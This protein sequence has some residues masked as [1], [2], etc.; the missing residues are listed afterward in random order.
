MGTLSLRVRYRPV[1][2]GW[3]VRDGNLED[4][5][6]VLRLTHTLWGGRY[7]PIIPVGNTELAT[8]LVDVFRVDALYPVVDDTQ[9]R[10][11]I[12]QFPH[13]PWP[14]FHK[15]FFIEGA[16]G[17]IATFL[18][19]YHPVRHLFEEFV[20]DKDEPRISATLYEWEHNDPLRDVFLAYFGSYP[21][22]DETG[23]DYS[24]FVEQ[25]LKGKR[26]KLGTTDAVPPDAYRA[27]TPS[28][29]SAYDLEGDRPPPREHPGLYVGSADD[30][31]D[32]VNFWNLRAADIAL[33]FDD[34]NHQGRLSGFTTSYLD[35]LR[36]RPEDPSGWLDRIAVWSKDRAAVEGKEFGPKILRRTVSEAIWNGL[37]LKPPLMQI[38]EEQSVLASVEDEGSTPSLSFQ[39]PKKPFFDDVGFFNQQVITSLRPLVGLS[40]SAETTF[41]YPYIP[42][43]NEYYG[44]DAHF[45]W[46][47]ARAERDGLGIVTSVTS[48]HLNIRALVKRQLVAKIFE[49]FGMKC[50]PSQPGRIAT[51][52]IHQMGGIQGCR[53]FKIAGVRK[54]IEKYGPLESFTRSGAVQVVGQN[55]PVTG[56]PNFADYEDLFIETRKRGKLKPEH[57]FTYLV[58][59]GVFRVGLNLECPNCDLNFWM[60]LDDIGTE[61]ECEYCGQ[62]FNITTQLRDRDWA[63][64]RSGLFGKEDH[65]QGSIPVLLTLQQLDTTLR[66]DTLFVTNMNIR[67]DTAQINP[68]ETDFVLIS[69][70][71]Y[72]DRVQLAIGECKS[73]GEEIEEKDVA[74]LTRVADAFPSKH[75]ETFIV[76]SKTAPFTP[77]EVAR[78]RAAQLEH[79]LRVVLLSDRELEPYFVYRRAEKEFNIRSTAI[80]LEAMA[81]ATHGIY[82]EPKPKKV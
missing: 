56:R 78:C 27:L 39:L 3:C 38:A 67:P 46:N 75:I 26:V 57:A 20:K 47:V 31:T 66:S 51:R 29:I 60:R 53:V 41:T 6:R 28:A 17:K 7:N 2:F 12:E 33:I 40:T 65:Q 32:I 36:E 44:R 22:K 69:H 48:D 52:L 24:S 11:F 54:L 18:D 70:K 73:S 80:S 74:N 61:M 34:S 19:V 81:H 16:W 35:K 4:V 76:F 58:K 50:E 13:L 43:L 15:E 42:Q 45:S 10:Q 59:K 30:F 68:C 37:N 55:D 63:Y 14:D 64:R 77:Q 62:R 1:R 71:G 8:Q 72:E 49:V 82:F 79:R 21:P 9:V 23:K 5:R 25:N